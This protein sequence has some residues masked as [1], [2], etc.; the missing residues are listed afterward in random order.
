MNAINQHEQNLNLH[1]NLNLDEDL[2]QDQDLISVSSYNSDQENHDIEWYIDH[3]GDYS[4]LNQNQNKN[5]LQLQF[6]VDIS[7]NINI[8]N[9][10]NII[11]CNICYDENN[12][13][14]FVKL[15][16]NHEFCHNCILKQL[17]SNNYNCSY[18]RVKISN[19]TVRKEEIK[20]YFNKY[21]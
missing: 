1:L 8:N 18:C 20:T 19:I 7:N 3:T 4:L 11:E 16:C 17:N 5:H 2:D 9:I 13:D 14:D 21:K 12:Y 15:P 10:N 6:I